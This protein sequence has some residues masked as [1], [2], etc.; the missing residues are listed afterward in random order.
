MARVREY[1]IVPGLL[2]CYEPIDR[3]QDVAVR[4]LAIYQG[5]DRVALALQIA[6]PIPRII[7]AVPE[8]VCRPIIVGYA[9][10]NSIFAGRWL[11]LWVGIKYRYVGSTTKC[12]H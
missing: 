10:Y 7:V 9:Y 1:D 12:H 11:W 4:C 3:A 2:L 5:L 6:L 8:V